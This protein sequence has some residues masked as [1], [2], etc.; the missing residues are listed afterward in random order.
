MRV[1]EC[2]IVLESHSNADGFESCDSQTAW[3]TP[4]VLK[5]RGPTHLNANAMLSD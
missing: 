2:S 4:A 1:D 3:L 5:N